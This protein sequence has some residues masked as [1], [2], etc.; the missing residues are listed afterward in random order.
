M[1]SLAP[2]KAPEHSQPSSRQHI[3]LI[4]PELLQLEVSRRIVLRPSTTVDDAQV[5]QLMHEL[6]VDDF[7]ED[8]SSMTAAFWV[9]GVLDNHAPRKQTPITK[10]RR[11][12]F[13]VI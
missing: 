11:P 7:E 3:Q 2:P 1:P 4:S 10:D 8:F 5:A 12:T 9:T 13:F 6:H